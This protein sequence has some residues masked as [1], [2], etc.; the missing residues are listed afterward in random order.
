MPLHAT[1]RAV[2]RI[3]TASACLAAISLPAHAQDQTR[4]IETI[5]VTGSHIARAT[6]EGALP[7]Q[8]IT[9]EQIERTGA[10]SAEQFL[11]T[12]SRQYRAT[13]TPSPQLRQEQMRVAYRA[14]RCAASARREH[15]CWSTDADCPAAER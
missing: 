2:N 10:T 9:K 4:N 12:V 14:Y 7:V 11:K 1:A 6:D 13:R 5:V 8:I 15:W 3:L